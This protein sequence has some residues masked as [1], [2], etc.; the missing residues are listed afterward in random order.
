[1]DAR[2]RIVMTYEYDMISNKILQNSMDAGRRWILYDAAGKALRSWDDKGR[3]LRTEYDELR[4]PRN[5]FV[6]ESGGTEQLVGRT[7][8]GEAAVNPEQ[9]NLRGKVYQAYDGAGEATSASYDFK[10]NLLQSKQR[11]VK[12]Y[13]A[14]P[15]WYASP[16]LESDVF[17]ASTRYD[18][19]NRPIQ[20]ISPCREGAPGVNVKIIQ[21]AYNETNLLEAMNVWLTQPALPG[22]GDD[23]LDTATAD[24]HAV[25][26]IDYN[27]K[28]QRTCVEYGNGVVTKYEYEYETYRLTR[29]RTTRTGFRASGKCVQ[30]ISYIYDPSGN[31]THINDAA[32][33]TIYFRGRVADPGATYTYDAIYRLV[34]AVGREHLGQSNGHASP[35]A[36]PEAFNGFHTGLDHPADGNAMGSY[37]ES[38]HY[39]EVGNMREMR[40]RGT[41]PSNPG[42]RRIYQYATDSDRLLSTGFG[43]DP[44]LDDPDNPVH[45][46]DLP[47]YTERYRYDV[48][49][50][51]ARM[52]HLASHPDPQNPNMHWNY[53]D[54]LQ[55]TDLGGG[56]TAYY[57]Y[58][59]SG[60]RTRKVWEKSPGLVE[61][62][63]Y[64]GGFE[65]FRKR[66]GR[67]GSI[68]LERET[69]HVM[70][71]KQRIAMVETRTM[72]TDNSPAQLIRYQISNHLGSACLELDE[73]AMVISYEEFYPYGSTS[74]QAV[75]KDIG[76]PLKR[77]RYSGKERDEESGLDYY[78]ARYYAGWLGRWTSCDPAGIKMSPNLYGFCKGN[79]VSRVDINGMADAPSRDPSQLVVAFGRAG[80]YM[81]TA[82]ANTG[83]QA[84]NIQDRI[85][86]SWGKG[87]G[88][89]PS[90]WELEKKF[91]VPGSS[92]KLYPM[93]SG[94]MAQ[95]AF[96]GKVAGTVHFDIRGVSLTPKIPKGEF[97]GFSS[98][99]YHSSSEVRQL[100]SYLGGTPAGERK[101]DVVIQ[102]EGGISRIGKNSNA[103]AGDALPK[104]FSERIGPAIVNAPA[105]GGIVNKL[106]GFG[107]ALGG[108]L[109]QTVKSMIPG[110]DIYD[111]VKIAGGGSFLA[112]AKIMGMAAKDQI[113]TVANA[114]IR[115]L[116]VVGE[117]TVSATTAAIRATGSALSSVCSALTAEVATGP[118]ATA[119]VTGAAIVAAAGSV[120]LAEESVRAAVTGQDTPI[121][122]ADKYFGTHFG[123]MYGWV[124]GAY[125]KK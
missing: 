103:V 84:I 4:R 61:E 95:E 41:D 107:R 5:S 104:S 110:A 42:W 22:D 74:Y 52:P 55:S 36:A 115:T 59:G 58:D 123:D 7:I 99:D 100:V 23:L 102:H 122:V 40:H 10:G 34:E 92:G 51:M 25:V 12:D 3:S 43:D 11:L 48:H 106:A 113:A 70:D 62:R 124:T 57:V 49:G 66:N 87:V 63:I 79:P 30:D 97:P 35:P 71:D 112:G 28:G 88:Y 29:L 24:F 37:T 93:F 38:Y 89:F 65:I 32:Q 44:H 72:G 119:G 15:D 105:R 56:G 33:Q 90:S 116:A 114:S 91:K 27:A 13:T 68:S 39:D 21:P 80:S 69:L 20:M 67:F 1:M 16:A 17:A 8:Y 118:V 76:V 26:N 81:E 54:E 96:E 117:K 111:M 19:L 77:Y 2:S 6:K 108:T 101:V 83:L 73:R 14:V 109:K 120:V 82:K 78:G 121:D 45:Y 46:S 31:I 53:M 85:N 125:S 50:N 64:L 86:F 9:K 18:A 98:A 75:R 94:V 47:L 60:Q